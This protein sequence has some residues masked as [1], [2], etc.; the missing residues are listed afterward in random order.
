MAGLFAFELALVQQ[1]HEV[2]AGFLHVKH[3]AVNLGQNVIVEDLEDDGNDQTRDGRDQ[4]HLDASYNDGRVDGVGLSNL[5]KA[6]II[7]ITVPAEPSIG[8]K[9]MNRLIAQAALGLD[10][11]RFVVF[12]G[13]DTSRSCQSCGP[14]AVV[15]EK[16][17]VRRSPA[18]LLGCVHTLAE[19]AFDS[20]EKLAVLVVIC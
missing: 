18:H 8:A 20:F 6:E 14:E 13:L 7:P 11:P 2:H 5:V 4:G 12:D 19:R 16:P 17:Q 10:I 1:V 9:A 3:D 15:M